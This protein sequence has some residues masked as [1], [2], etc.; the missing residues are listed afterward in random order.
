V[1]SQVLRVVEAAYAPGGDEQW[2]T[3]VAETALN[4]LGVGRGVATYTFYVPPEP[5]A[6]PL[7]ETYVPRGG[8]DLGRDDL[9]ALIEH[10]PVAL[11]RKMFEFNGV[12][13]M[14]EYLNASLQ[15]MPFAEGQ[16]APVGF[17]DALGIVSINPSGRGIVITTGLPEPTRLPP[18]FKRTWS[19]V[20]AHLSAGL[21]LRSDAAGLRPR[22]EPAGL[23]PGSAPAQPAVEAVLAPDGKVLDASGPARERE[24]RA[25]LRLAVDR[26]R[27]SQEQDPAAALELWRGLVEG[28]W[29]LLDQFDS[30]GRRFLVARAN[31]VQAPPL[32]KLSPAERQVVALAALG[33][34]NK[35]I[36]YELGVSVGT[37]GTLLSRAMHKLRLGSRVQ[38]I[39]AWQRSRHE[40]AE[41]QP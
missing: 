6:K 18:A 22:G 31:T 26:A 28:R 41:A 4:A 10:A 7:I 34:T 8:L 15:S 30:D 19:R 11:A 32:R 40:D 9:E 35:L 38:L 27:S 29:S 1:K 36:A 5:T 3:G 39:E 20:M 21:R 37:V 12:S 17:Q 25:A 24:A 33:R 2:L 13:T 23:H 14:T 16:M